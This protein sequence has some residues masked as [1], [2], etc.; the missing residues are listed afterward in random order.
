[1][2]VLGIDHVGVLVADLDE[3]LRFYAERLGLPAGPIETF[4]DPP[5]RRVCVR[6]GEAE[7][8]LIE[9]RDAEGTMMRFLPHRHPGPYHVALS[10]D[11]VD[12]AAA[13]LRAAGLPLID[14]PREGGDMRIQY[15]HPDAAAGCM[16]E[17][18][19]RRR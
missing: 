19:T 2:K 13:G 12:E 3:A 7:L 17:L 9:T 11:D 6:V 5:I 4:D 8:E 1:M 10:V 15:L 14:S 18:V 16:I